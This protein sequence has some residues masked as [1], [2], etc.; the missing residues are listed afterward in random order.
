MEWNWWIHGP[1]ILLLVGLCVIFYFVRK[2][3]QD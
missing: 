2:N 3:Q 1:L